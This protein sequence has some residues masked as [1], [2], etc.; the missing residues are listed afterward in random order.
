MKGHN[1]CCDCGTST[2]AE[3]IM[4]VHCG[5]SLQRKFPALLA[6][7]ISIALAV[8]VA[9]AGYFILRPGME[10]GDDGDNNQGTAV[11]KENEQL[12]TG[13][14]DEPVRIVNNLPEELIRKPDAITRLVNKLPAH[15]RKNTEETPPVPKVKEETLNEPRLPN[16]SRPVPSKT[17]V[18]VFSYREMNSYGAVCSY[19]TGRSK[20]N[21]VFFTNNVYGYV[22]VNGKVYTLQGVQKG[23][24]IA[25]FSGAGYEVTIEILGLAGSEKEWLAEATMVLTDV[26]Q[27]TLTRH[28]IYSTCTEF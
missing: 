28:K 12:S 18:N 20:S 4:C 6:I 13:K 16:E 10:E 2:L 11:K 19:F 22:K 7:L 26:R 21:V 17:S 25:R 3:A 23:N 1:Y 5:A 15:P 14:K 24:D 27:R 9:V 8:S